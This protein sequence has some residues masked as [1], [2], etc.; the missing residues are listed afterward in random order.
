[1]ARTGTTSLNDSRVGRATLRVAMLL[2]ALRALIPVGYMPDLGGLREGQVQ[3]VICTGTGTQVL[4]VD[5]AGQPL[6]A[7]HTPDHAG[8]ADCAFATAS[9]S[10]LALPAIVPVLA[11]P[12]VAM[13]ALPDTAGHALL[14]PAQGPPLGSRAPPIFLG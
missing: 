12:A 6:D 1:M 9:A 8:A 3:I 7:D 10:G 2:F 13:A 4:L 11:R 14:A 5:A